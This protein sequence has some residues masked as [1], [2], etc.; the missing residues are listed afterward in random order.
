MTTGNVERIKHNAYIYRVLKQVHP[1]TGIS[2]SALEIMNAL[3]GVVI[4]KTT[5]NINQFFMRSDKKTIGAREVQSAVRLTFPG[6]LGKHAVS[7]GTKAVTKYGAALEATDKQRKN[8]K[9]K[10][11]QRSKK[12]GI[13]F[14]VTRVEKMMVIES[15]A[16]RKSANAAV[17][18]AAVCEYVTAEILE[19]AGNAARDWQKVRITPR[20][21]KLAICNDGELSRLFRDTIIPGGVTPS[22]R[23]ELLP[24][25]KEEKPKKAKTE[26]KKKPA[27]KKTGKTTASTKKTTAKKGGAKAT[28]KSA[29]KKGGTKATAKSPAKKGVAKS[30]VKKGKGT[31]KKGKA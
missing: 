6:E 31:A 4:T 21:I 13:T 18:L 7:E 23:Q 10:P 15:N 14:N 17:Y 24:A 29:A 3:V 5:K 30:P 9:A 25:Q 12:A 20:M 26:A 19:L 28:T 8:G 1:D 27:A 2:G 16:V 11:E 22:I